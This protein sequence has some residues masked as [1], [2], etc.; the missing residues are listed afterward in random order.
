MTTPKINDMPILR[1]DAD[2][3]DRVRL[4]IGPAARDRQLWIVFIDGDGRQVPVMMPISDMPE[5]P[6]PGTTAGLTTVLGGLR[7]DLVTA[8]GE[9]SVALVLER[10]GPDHVLPRDR[11]WA[12][13]LTRAG[14]D[15]EVALRGLFLSTPGG[16]Q[17]L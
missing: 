5:R 3:L 14:A 7:P 9:G 12:E 11:D 17:Q 4:L 13:A 10:H 1:T 2:L 6:E 8:D 16:V 15:G